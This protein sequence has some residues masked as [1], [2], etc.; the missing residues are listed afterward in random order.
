MSVSKKQYDELL[1]RV[2]QLERVK[3]VDYPH[4]C[5]YCKFF[6]SKK[7]GD[8]R[9][10]KYPGSVSATGESCDMWVLEPDGKRR[11]QSWIG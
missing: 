7:P 1:S 3:V 9:Y 10:C 6:K 2:K 4:V 11:V 5:F 8:N